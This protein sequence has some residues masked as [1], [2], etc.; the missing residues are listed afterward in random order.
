MKV[1]IGVTERIIRIL[2]GMTIITVALAY[3]SWWA[4]LGIEIALTGIFG[5]SPIYMFLGAST[6]HHAKI[7]RGYFA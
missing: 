4:L 3:N 1:N 2:I 5:W 6:V 7:R